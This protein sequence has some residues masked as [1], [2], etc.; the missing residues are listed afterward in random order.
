MLPIVRVYL[1][2]P[3][4][5][6]KSTVARVLAERLGTRSLD[7]DA[8]VEERAGRSIPEIFAERGESAFRDFE[9][10]ALRELPSEVGVVSLG[11]GTVV[12][13]ET[14]QALLRDGILITLMADPSVL[15]SRVGKGEGRPLL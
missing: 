9:K 15:A 4:G 7:L 2:G 14:R 3:M 6:G 1:S 13:D 11:G 5:A 10:Q 12:D 8:V